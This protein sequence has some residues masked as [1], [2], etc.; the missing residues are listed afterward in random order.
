LDVGHRAHYP[1]TTRQNMRAGLP[2]NTSMRPAP[3][4][5]VRHSRSTRGTHQLTR[6]MSAP[7]ERSRS[8]MRS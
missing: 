4:G 1:A 8:S 3:A 2:G 6:W 5:S 7:S